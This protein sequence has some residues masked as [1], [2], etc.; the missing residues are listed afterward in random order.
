MIDSPSGSLEADLLCQLVVVLLCL[1]ELP[2]EQ[3]LLY[4][5][6]LP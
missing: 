6:G 5:L 1:L 4:L 2:L 3:V